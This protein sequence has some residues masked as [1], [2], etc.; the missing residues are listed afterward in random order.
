[1]ELVHFPRNRDFTSKYNFINLLS[2]SSKIEK[3]I[4]QQTPVT[5]YI[6]IKVIENDEGDIEEDW[7]N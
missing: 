3:I 4:I 5:K 1:M 7:Q 2:N 6:M